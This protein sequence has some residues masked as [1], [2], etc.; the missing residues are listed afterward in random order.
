MTVTF[1][2]L[3]YTPGGNTTQGG[4]GGI[5]AYDRGEGEVHA[6]HKYLTMHTHILQKI[7]ADLLKVTT[8]HKEQ[9]S[10]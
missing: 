3:N 4:K 10:P 2:V 1:F 6:A 8:R 9:T 5:S 7:F